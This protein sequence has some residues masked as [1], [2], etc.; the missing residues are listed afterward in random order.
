MSTHASGLTP[1]PQPQ[2]KLADHVLDLFSLK[3]KVASVT[4]SSSG[5]GLAVAEAFA[6]AGADVALWYHGNPKAIEHAKTLS[7]KYGVKVK[8]YK[9]SIT[10]SAEVEQ[11]I[12]QI[13]ADFGKLDIQV[14]NAGIP[15]TSGPLIDVEGDEDWH[16]IIDTDLNG[17]Y[18]TAKFSGQQFKKQGSG[19][20]IF[21]ASMSGHIV[22]IPQLQAA[23][24][25]AKAG[26]LHFARSLAIE[27]AGFARVNTVSPGYILTEIS[28][29]VPIETKKIWWE[30]IPVGREGQ[31]KELVGAY[32]YLASDASTYTTGSDLRVDGAYA[33]P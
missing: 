12:K 19:S 7:E 23:Y 15:W 33:A 27:W 6:Q 30:L 16:K 17:A 9:V 28:N 4:G 32:L 11:T 24:N 2:P 5:I 10:S 26:V 8:A 22:N 25:A 29:F 3:G 18:Y 31:T 20:L 13:V 21:T 1:L 14:A